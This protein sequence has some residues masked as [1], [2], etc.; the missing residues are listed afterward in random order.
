MCCAEGFGWV[1][2]EEQDDQVNANSFS[3]LSSKPI[4]SL[5][6]MDSRGKVEAG[7]E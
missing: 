1:D 7:Q 3:H 5:F 2:I 4:G 6:L